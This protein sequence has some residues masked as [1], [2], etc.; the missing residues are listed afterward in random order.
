MLQYYPC[1][2]KIFTGG[3]GCP[4][5]VCGCW[6]AATD[7][8]CWDCCGCCCCTCC[9]MEETPAVVWA[10]GCGACAANDCWDGMWPE[11]AC[12]AGRLLVPEWCD[13]WLAVRLCWDDWWWPVTADSSTAELETTDCTCD[14]L[15]TVGTFWNPREGLLEQLNK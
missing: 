6:T 12:G 15:L 8:C 10:C 2:N 5:L 7:D 14:A 11:T 9:D 3:V 1:W 4:W 13:C